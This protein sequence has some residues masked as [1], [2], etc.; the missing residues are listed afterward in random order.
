MALRFLYFTAVQFFF[1]LG[2]IIASLS[3]CCCGNN[4]QAEDERLFSLVVTFVFGLMQ[5]FLW[6]GNVCSGWQECFYVLNWGWM[7][8]MLWG[9]FFVLLASK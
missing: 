5:F 8:S 3:L 6:V 7:W 2:T 4:D 9:I 1:R